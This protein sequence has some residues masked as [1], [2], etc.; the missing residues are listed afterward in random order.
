MPLPTKAEVDWNAPALACVKY[1][2][3]PGTNAKKNCA[4]ALSY[5]LCI[6]TVNEYINSHN[7]DLRTQAQSEYTSSKTSW[8]N[9]LASAMDT[10]D[11]EEKNGTGDQ[12]CGECQAGWKVKWIKQHECGGTQNV[13]Q[14]DATT[15]DQERAKWK[16]AHSEPQQNQFTKVE[17]DHITPSITNCCVNETNIVNSSL[18]NTTINQTCIN[19]G[20]I[21]SSNVASDGTTSGTGSTTI[22]DSSISSSGSWKLY[23]VSVISL[24]LSSFVLLLLL[25]L[26]DDGE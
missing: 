3:E 20:V 14:R 16:G 17:V 24:I 2:K 1:K 12:G 7:S 18:S 8:D 4:S 19:D 10:L 25:L 9:Q 26:D 11:R 23:V 22:I 21:S 5:A 6:S 15:M 13:C